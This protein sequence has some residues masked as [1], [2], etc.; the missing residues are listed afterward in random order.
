M[1]EQVAVAVLRMLD[2]LGLCHGGS[3][4]I[5]AFRLFLFIRLYWCCNRFFLCLDIL[6]DMSIEGH[7][8]GLY[9]TADTQNG[10]LSVVG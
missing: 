10:N 1:R 2:T 3:L 8:K 5:T 4:L 9:A 6:H 7:G